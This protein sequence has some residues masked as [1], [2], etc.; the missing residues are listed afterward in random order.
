MKRILLFISTLSIWVLLQAQ[1]LP[2]GFFSTNATNTSEWN[3]PVGAAFSEDGN[4]LFIWEKRGH[5][6]VSN[7]NASIGLHYKQV[8]EVIDISEE[9]GNWSDM[10]LLGFALDPN[11]SSTGGYIYLFYVVDRYYLLNSESPS[12]D[13]VPANLDK[14]GATIGRITRY[15]TSIVDGNLVADPTS[16]KILL[17]ETITTGIPILHLS[18]SVGTL[19]FAADGTLLATTGDG[20]SYEDTDVGEITN[21][22]PAVGT[23]TFYADALA[24]GI[25]TANEDV[26][27]FR[28][29]MLN[30]LS[31][32]LL[33]LNRETG[34]GMSS[35]P[36]F[37]ANAP[38]SAKS[39][40]WA[41]GFRNPFR[42]SVKPG[43]GS[44]NP[45]AG[46][47]GEI[48]VGDVGS[49]QAEELNIVTA[50][51]QNFGWPIYEGS[52]PSA[53]LNKSYWGYMTLQNNDEPVG[54]SCH[55]NMFF[56]ELLIQDNAAK[57]S[58]I[59]T[60][61]ESECGGGQLFGSGNRFIHA[62]PV[63]EWGHDPGE[64]YVPRFNEQGQATWLIIGTP[65]SNVTADSTFNGN[66]S[67]G[68][69][70]LTGG[71]NA[72]FPPEY[73]NTFLVSDFGGRWVRRVGIDY[74]D[75][76]TSVD[77]FFINNPS[78]GDG[79]VVCMAENPIDGS[80]VYI[81]V[82]LAGY[83]SNMA[84]KKIVFGGNVPPVAQIGADKYFSATSSLTV[85]FTG[86]TSYDQDGNVTTY[87]WDFGDPDSGADN[88]SS[89]ANPTHV[90]TTATGVPKK[91]V[92]TLAVTD[93]D[94][95]TSEEKQFIISL[96]NIPP[97]VSIISPVDDSK[98]KIGSD[99]A[100]TLQANVTDNPSQ[101]LTHAWQTS[102][103]HENHS[104]SNPIDPNEETTAMISR[105]GCEGDDYHWFITL[106]VTD[107]AGLSTSDTSQIY[108]NCSTALPLI[109]RSF[110]VTQKVSVNLV[111][112]TTELESNIEYFEVERSYDGVNF[113]PINRQEARNTPG[114][115]HYNFADNDL[116]PGIIY[117]RLK[118]VEHGSIIRYSVIIRTTTEGENMNLKIVPN[119][120][121]YNFSVMYKSLQDEVVT[122]QIKDIT[123]RILHTLKE[124]V[125]RGQN[126]IYLQNLPTWPAGVYFLSLQNKEEVKQIKFIKS[127][128]D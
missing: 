19:A 85:N 68:G 112:W 90:F 126:V 1:V 4:Q 61:S 34:D 79:A 124:G 114:I 39:R 101:T 81:A 29:Q 62:R 49:G 11:F 36:F 59:Y 30:S 74:S 80:L 92:V 57:I 77:D 10:G 115:S 121:V 23:N 119:P 65:E 118:M 109:L 125:N 73:K 37:D 28:S 16:R 113:Y 58:D 108:P 95:L 41:L 87:S 45:S 9:V 64:V 107:D 12:Y 56:H 111:K 89:L 7:R 26:G 53:E 54:T 84:V 63:L 60:P 38:H 88:F 21:D 46:D 99:T 75:V 42:M 105:I 31:G 93:D 94:A 27:A 122:I 14:P 78:G 91:Y 32:K 67:T 8:L 52:A 48:F 71:T 43:A 110:S 97:Q 51:G 40:V 103:I 47:I 128:D 33:R 70:W 127:G 35:N 83:G 69:I 2:T 120:V 76:V 22:D 117:Y 5:V 104:H 13:P 3:E 116:S 15:T 55:R 24:D 102:L 106:K 17:G 20:A 66:A 98:Y 25:I 123:G 72:T 82:G 6:Y 100:Y 96:N 18:H 44:E 50:P 86:S